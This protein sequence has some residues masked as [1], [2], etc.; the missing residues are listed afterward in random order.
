[1]IGSRQESRS[2]LGGQ[3]VVV[4]LFIYLLF[5][6]VLYWVP[7]RVSVCVRVSVDE[8]GEMRVRPLG[9]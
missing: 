5:F 8:E 3:G 9:L 4:L 6:A 7:L 2:S 1:M